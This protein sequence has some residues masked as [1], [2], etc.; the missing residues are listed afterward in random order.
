VSASLAPIHIHL[1]ARCPHCA[2]ELETPLGCAKCGNL[3]ELAADPT[4]FEIFGLKPAMVLDVQEEQRTLRKL[5]RL[6]HPDFFATQSGE[7]RSRAERASALVNAAHEILADDGRRA[8]WLVRSLGGP[9]ENTLREMP[10][11]FLLEVLE[12]NER[13]EEAR[14]S[15][16]PIAA[17]IA[18]LESSL[19]EQRGAILE[20]LGRALD[21]LPERGSDNLRAARQELNALRYVDR[22][23]E[24]IEA[25]RL[26]KS[27]RC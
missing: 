2:A 15:T 26:S 9:D 22:A 11:P 23:L 4:P 24:E 6:T 20:S 7:M 27:A 3:L 5:G 14:R 10:K 1:M 12:W 19:R 21:P 16:E 8:D 13:L 18:S 17:E 25:L